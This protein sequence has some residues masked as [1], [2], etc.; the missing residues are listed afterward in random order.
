VIRPP[1]LIKQYDEYWSEDPAFEQAPKHPGDSASEE[2]IKSYKEADADYTTR[3]FAAWDTGNWQS[4]RVQGGGEPTKF[5]MR[6]LPSEAGGVLADM[7]KAGSG[8]NELHTLAF[9]I[10][11]L[12]I[13][14]LEGVKVAPT[15]DE[16]FGRIASLSWMTDVG[17]TGALGMRLINELGSRVIY[18]ATTIGPK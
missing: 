9:R 15:D 7:R 12:G 16:R 11:L 8:D 3:L 2:E 17:L 5:L 13:S 10:A 6:P 4:L 14:N 1:S 18:K